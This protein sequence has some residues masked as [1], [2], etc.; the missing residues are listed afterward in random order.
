MLLRYRLA[1]S[2]WRAFIKPDRRRFLRS[3]DVPRQTQ[4]NK[5]RLLLSENVNTLFGRSH[6]FSQIKNLR[7][8]QK[9][10]PLSCYEEFI[11]YIDLIRQGESNIL[12][13]EKVER[14][15][16]SSGTSSASKLIPFTNALR[17]EF[18]AGIAPWMANLYENY[19]KLSSGSS[20]WV[21]SPSAHP[22]QLSESSVEIGFDQD[23]SY[24]PWYIRLPQQLLTSRS[25]PDTNEVEPNTIHRETALALLCDKSLSLI[26]VWNPSYFRLIL[27]EILESKEILLEQLC[28]RTNRKRSAEIRNAIGVDTNDISHVDWNAV[29]PN[30]TL[31]S[32][33][34]DAWAKDEARELQRLFPDS[35]VQGKGL[36]AT[37]GFVTL[38]YQKKGEL[39]VSPVLSLNSHVFEF[40]DI[41]R[42]DIR[43]ADELEKNREYEVIIS[44][45]SGLYRYRLGDIV[46]CVGFLGRTP[47][48]RFLRKTNNVS[49]ICGEKINGEHIANILSRAIEP[50]GLVQTDVFI[51]PMPDDRPPHYGLYVE[52]ENREKAQLLRNAIEEMMQ[53]NFHYKNCRLLGQLDTLRVY[54]LDRVKW[55]D[56]QFKNQRSSTTKYVPLRLQF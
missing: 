49:D 44:T 15:H 9:V 19:P 17:K 42:G 5:L 32:C 12:T 13:T 18:F 7:Q 46:S 20:Y 31:I 43:F 34:A 24:L 2:A 26:S 48:L 47:S 16:L 38:P 25:T 23:T 52:Y 51:A 54:S 3:V 27:E 35:V 4:E 50:L 22:L 36:L 14:L 8:F 1:N 11:P 55:R 37:E 56:I 21:V 30:L 53:E 41:D 29:W 39:S 33:W 45:A 28:Q 10:V 40:M 6:N